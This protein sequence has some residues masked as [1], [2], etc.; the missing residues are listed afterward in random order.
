VPAQRTRRGAIELPQGLLQTAL[1]EIRPRAGE[2]RHDIKFE[3]RGG[4]Y[5]GYNL[6]IHA[7]Y[8]V[9]LEGKINGW[10]ADAADR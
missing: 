5:E 4:P 8:L 2:I 9:D 6:G 1:S 10:I 3:D 7:P